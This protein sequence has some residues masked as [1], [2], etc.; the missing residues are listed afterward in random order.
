MFPITKIFNQNMKSWRNWCAFT[1][2]PDIKVRF[3]DSEWTRIGVIVMRDFLRVC[4]HD[5]D[6][7]DFSDAYEPGISS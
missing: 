2:F 1:T 7:K 5:L 3:L 6:Q 4:V